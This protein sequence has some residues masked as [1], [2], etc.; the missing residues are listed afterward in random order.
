MAVAEL[1]RL[2]CDEHRLAWDTAWSLCQRTF[3]YTNHTLMPEA[4]ETWPVALVQRLLPRHLEIIY[5]INHAFLQMAAAHRPEDHAFFSRLSLID[6]GGER[7][8]R[9]PCPSWAAT[10]ST[11]YRP[12]TPN[13]WSKPCLPTL[14]TCG[15]SALSM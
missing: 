2:L 5:R 10:G 1:M 4:L 6:E 14:P 7:R 12:C 15:P 11:G 13:C 9:S 8:V 3:S